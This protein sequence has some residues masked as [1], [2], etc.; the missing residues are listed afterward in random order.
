MWKGRAHWQGVHGMLRDACCEAEALDPEGERCL[1][2]AQTE[3]SAQD[4]HIGE[5]TRKL[6]DLFTHV[7]GFDDDRE[8][9]LECSQSRQRFASAQHRHVDIHQDEIKCE[10]FLQFVE[11]FLAMVGDDDSV[12]KPAQLRAHGCLNQVVVVD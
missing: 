6:F 2:L 12:P 9:R 10:T 1:E 7:S 11:G 5:G 3:R 4:R 8:C